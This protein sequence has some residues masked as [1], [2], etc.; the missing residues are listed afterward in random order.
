MDLTQKRQTNQIMESKTAKTQS[1][2]TNSIE[3]RLDNVSQKVI[4]AE[5]EIE[6]KRVVDQNQNTGH[7]NHGGGLVNNAS[8]NPDGDPG[9]SH[10]MEEISISYDNGQ[11][12]TRDSIGASRY[13]RIFPSPINRQT[14]GNKLN[15]KTEQLLE[16]ER[17]E[18]LKSKSSFKLTI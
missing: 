18:L 5:R 9:K 6:L 13:S 3:T 17:E 2:T 7:Q 4:N 14:S 12:R 1:N 15:Q 16:L 8:E 11:E 10:S